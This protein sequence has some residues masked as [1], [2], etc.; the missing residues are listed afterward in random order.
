MIPKF[1]N[2]FDIRDKIITSLEKENKIQKELIKEQKH[3]IL[4]LEEQVSELTKLLKNI[5]KA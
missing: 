2:G 4:I 3:M 5:L 1:D